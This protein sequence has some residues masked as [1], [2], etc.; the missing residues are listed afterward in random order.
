[1]ETTLLQRLWQAVTWAYAC[2]QQFDI[3]P[4]S[5]RKSNRLASLVLFVSDWATTAAEPMS[6]YMVS[7]GALTAGPP[8]ALPSDLEDFVQSAGEHG[9]VYASL[10]TTAI[11]G[12]PQSSRQNF[13]VH[14][15]ANTLSK[16]SMYG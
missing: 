2:R 7:I 4:Y 1:M 13:N 5:Y 15:Q 3:P 9:V 6:P 11:P 12:N 10:G 16:C 14:L 8:K